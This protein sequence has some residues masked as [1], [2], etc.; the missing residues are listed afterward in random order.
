MEYQGETANIQRRLA[1]TS[2]LY[3]RRLAVLNAMSLR[4][5]EH[6]LEVGCGGGLLLPVM[7]AAVGSTGRVTGI[8]VSTD[9]IDAARKAC[10]GLAVVE[11]AIVDVND[12]PY[13][14]ASFDVIACIQVIEYLEDP[15]HALRELRR[16]CRP[17]G[18]IVVFATNWDTM[19]WNG[20][21]PDQTLR[22][23]TAW[24]EHAPFPNLP[25]D[26]GP[27]LADAG[28]RMVSQ[29]PVTIVNNAYHEDAF[30]YW[31]ARLMANYIKGKDWLPAS[32]VDAWIDRLASAQ[33][34]GRFFFSSTPILTVAVT[35]Q[36]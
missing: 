14:D 2:D 16:V 29:A 13:A 18:R 9:Q 26:I 25:A 23:A 36:S 11:A 27:F 8:D 24:R 6:V 3:R 7:A 10:A 21:D 32:D 15:A 17:N 19:F 22:I 30:G 5:G 34:E 4:P 31:I 1:E 35:A 28:F 33:E 20:P 12:L